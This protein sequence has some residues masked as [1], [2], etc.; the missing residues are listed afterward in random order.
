MWPDEAMI[1]L[2]G[3]DHTCQRAL[4]SKG[5]T[6]R[7]IAEL[8]GKM[9]QIVDGLVDRVA[10]RGEC[11]LVADFARPLPMRV[12][13][14]MLGYPLDRQDE[15]LD[16]TDV[17]VDAGSGG[18]ENVT[19]EVIANFSNFCGFHQELLKQRRDA[20][21]DD[22][23]SVW[24]DA[25]IDGKRLGEDKILYEHNLLLVGGSETTRHAISVGMLELLKR[26]EDLAH[27]REH[28]EAIPNAIEEMVRFTSPFVRMQ[29]TLLQDHVFYG[30][31]M[32]EGDK[33]LVLY[34]AANRDPRVWERPQAFD[35][36]RSFE[37]PALAFGYGKHYCLGASL[38]RLEIKVFLERILARWPDLRLSESRPPVAKTSAFLRGLGSLPVCF[39]KA[40]LSAGGQ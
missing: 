38:A 34:P 1:N 6:P 24:L 31:T 32:K 8:E 13:G 35:I 23:L 33:I 18:I 14:E 29:R 27:L 3:D 2:D 21:G 12:I 19:G 16:W 7:R 10:A 30:T 22:L 17:Y 20:R 36:H 4:V 37:K 39:G 40:A 28:P 15:V 5:F 11:D 26:P 9:R 25:E